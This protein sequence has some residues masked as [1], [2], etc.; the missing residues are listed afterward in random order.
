MTLAQALTPPAQGALIAVV[1]VLIGVA[2]A[3]MSR[4]Y[5]PGQTPW[6]LYFGALLA[7]LAVLFLVAIAARVP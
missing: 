4:S 1:I 7:V 5:R 2:A 6:A 3:F